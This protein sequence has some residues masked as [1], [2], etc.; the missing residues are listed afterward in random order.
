MLKSVIY[1]FYGGAIELKKAN[2]QCLYIP[3]TTQKNF[4]AKF[5]PRF[6]TMRSLII[7]IEPFIIL[8]S[9]FAIYFFAIFL[10]QQ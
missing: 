1:T 2:I 8:P 3:P 4:R 7:E 10:L 5:F 6:F 9:N